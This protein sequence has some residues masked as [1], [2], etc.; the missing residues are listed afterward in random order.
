MRQKEFNTHGI[1]ILLAAVLLAV[2]L[3]V[4]NTHLR[5]ILHASALTAVERAA[6]AAIQDCI[7]C[8][9]A[10]GTFR[11]EAFISMHTDQNGRV[12]A[13]SC[14]FRQM[15][16]LRASLLT[17]LRARLS[18]LCEHDF[19]IP[20]GNLTNLS[21]LSGRGPTITV[22][23]RSVGSVNAEF[24][25]NFTE[26]GINQTL[27]QI[28]LQVNVS[29][30]VFLPGQRLEHPLSTRMTVAETVIVGEVPEIYVHTEQ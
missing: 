18:E 7:R 29:V 13:L 17:S 19:S 8:E 14:D 1:S 11:Y 4:T 6:V 5:P 2:F 16:L 23:V 9:L 27:H 21:I 26:A 20:F 30:T 12:T 25:H 24:E 28:V 3:S 22:R 15:N 10:E